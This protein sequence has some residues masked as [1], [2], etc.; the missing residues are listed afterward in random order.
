MAI[1]GLERLG[2]ERDPACAA[3]PARE[4]AACLFHGFSDRSRLAI[5]QHLVLGEHRVGEL[6]AHLDLAQS[7]VSKHLACL[8][9]CGLVVSRPQGRASMFSLTHPDEVLALLQAAEALLAL[10]GEAVA[11]CPRY[12]STTLQELRQP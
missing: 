3:S 10:T 2:L 11:L 7:T 1:L 9:E 12:G 8:R 5:L 4:V 6:A